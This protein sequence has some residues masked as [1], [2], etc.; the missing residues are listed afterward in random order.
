[1]TL[2]TLLLF[3]HDQSLHSR[4][5]CVATVCPQFRHLN[6]LVNMWIVH[7]PAAQLIRMSV[8]TPDHIKL[9]LRGGQEP[10]IKIKQASTKKSI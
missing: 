3:I 9:T 7:L 5:T 6:P 2:P 4:P 1:M 10:S 8:G